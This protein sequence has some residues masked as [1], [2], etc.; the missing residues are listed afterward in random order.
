MKF[1]IKHCSPPNLSFRSN[2]WFVYSLQT[3]LMI[4][5]LIKMSEQITCYHLILE[6]PGI[7]VKLVDFS[8]FILASISFNDEYVHFLF[9]F[10]RNLTLKH[11]KRQQTMME[12]ITK[13]V[14]LSSKY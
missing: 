10:Y 2:L 11:L 9:P 5:K 14:K 7:S 1:T 8:H 4:N 13:I 3:Q 6:N 12:V